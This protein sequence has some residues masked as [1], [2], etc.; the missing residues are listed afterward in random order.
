MKRTALI[1][2]AL[3]AATL[4]TSSLL[5]AGLP[6]Q[7]ALAADVTP[8]RLRNPDR[9]PQNWLMNHRSYDGQRFSPLARI[10]RD[11][12]RNLKLAYAVPLAG[13][14]GREFIEA[15]PLAEDGFLYVTDSFGVLYRIDA[16][17]GDVGRIVWRMDPKQDRQ[18]ANRGAAF[19]GNL[20]I[21]PASGPARVIAADKTTGAI[22]WET[23]VSDT[24]RVTITGAPL[25]IRDK[26]IIGASGGD[27]GVRD[28]VA[29]LDA[30]TGKLLWRK[31]T[32]PA[33]GEPGSE[34]WKDKN[35][36]W[37]TGGGAVWVTGTYDPE[38]DQ[39]LWG[40]GNPVPMMDAR[41]RPGDNLYTNS[42][43]SYEPDSGKMNWY[44]QYT[45]GD[46]WD[47][48][49]VGT[50]ILIDRVIN[51]QPRKLVTHSA[52]NGFVYTMERASGAM[53]GAKPY[54]DVNWTKGIDQK[55]GRPLDYDPN[56]DVQTYSGIADPTK[57]NP[58]K[59]VCPSR[60]GGNNYMPSSYSPKTQLLYIPATT[61]CEI[62]TNDTDLVKREKGWY[63]RTGGGY[64]VDSRYESNLT[65]VDPVTLEVR[66][67][68][69]L[70]YPNY[71][72]TL[73]TAGGVVFLALLDGTVAAFDD[74]TLDPLWKVN[75]GSGFAAPP[76]TF[77]AGGKQYIA[78]ASGASS[79]A[80]T[81]LLATPELNDQRN[82]TVLYV[83][84]L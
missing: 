52:R 50:H 78:I 76:M 1:R 23:N 21:S 37:R 20:V 2:G 3:L 34:T 12:V 6:Y 27:A 4:L 32:I 72:G 22:V 53:V 13:T 14:A 11:N 30:A 58:V 31:Y 47:F 83:F 40:V 29:G 9:E 56:K 28:W 19:W 79:T 26:I 70:P 24:E 64:K 17:A 71:S 33:P 8:D 57:E 44:F 7:P 54:M 81:K 68:A 35:N 51:G 18:V 75:V 74:T 42:V 62:V 15:T 48:D 80:R 43:V 5:T 84:G 65:A 10:N 36:A 49:E 41:L 39:T 25:A 60:V 77:E 38:T 63:G 45:P 69:H 16:T 61:A 67:N 59:K 46:M 82:A 73:A 66:K 55:T